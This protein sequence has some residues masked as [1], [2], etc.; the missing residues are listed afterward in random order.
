M[1]V[2]KHKPPVLKCLS[3]RQ[4]WASLI[5]AGEKKVENR[6][7]YT[8]HRGPLLIHA[9]KTVDLDACRE[10]R[11]DPESLPTGVILGLVNVADC[12]PPEEPC[13]SRWADKG[14]HHWLLADPQL[15]RNPV[16]FIGRVGLFHVPLN[17]L[18]KSLGR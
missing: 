1:P 16:H 9:S 14:A 2:R 13:R 6:S 8:R 3:L 4:P 17:C 7:W 18:G 12:L 10:H 5:V 11:L 15:L